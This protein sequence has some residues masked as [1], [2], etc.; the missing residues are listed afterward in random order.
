MWVEIE[1]DDEASS[2]REMNDLLNN[3]EVHD[4][5]DTVD[6][7]LFLI[8]LVVSPPIGNWYMDWW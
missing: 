2:L 6:R 3:R 8:M 4:D 5:L 7:L 1:E